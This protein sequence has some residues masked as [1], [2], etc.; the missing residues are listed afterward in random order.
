MTFYFLYLP[1][2][3]KYLCRMAEPGCP[4]KRRSIAVQGRQGSKV[5]YNI[6]LGQVM[7]FLNN[8]ERH[9]KIEIY[10]NLSNLSSRLKNRNLT[11]VFV[12]RARCSATW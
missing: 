5:L 3:R 6:A 2:S 8:Y 10:L 7:I 4:N 11:R 12:Q 1:N 9:F